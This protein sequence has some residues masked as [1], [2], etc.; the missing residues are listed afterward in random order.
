MAV[1]ATDLI[2]IVLCTYNRSQSLRQTLECLATQQ[3]D[4]FDYEVVVVD[5]NSPDDTKAVVE[6]CQPLFG[7]RLRYVFEGRQ[8]KPYALNT[9][10]AAARGRVLALTDDDVCPDPRWLCRLAE[11]FRTSNAECVFGKILP[12]WMGARPAWL[13]AFFLPQLA[14]LDYGDQAFLVTS[15]R[16]LFFGANVALTKKALARVG[17]FNVRL[18]NQGGR[19]GGE[20]DTDLF[21]RL[22]AA[23]ARI[24]YAPEAVVYHK[25]PA[26]RLRLGYFRKWHFDHGLVSAYVTPCTRGRGVLGV[27]FWAIRKFLTHLQGYLIGLCTGDRERRLANEMRLICDLGLFVEKGKI[28]A[29]RRLACGRS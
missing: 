28:A 22:L 17:P 19:M 21:E 3:A 14:L 13:S 25:V 18:G 10:V 8:G 7:G 9:G 11:V 6:R 12:L 15:D 4:G 5:N 24:A 1:S 16:H 26:E 2:S 23:G 27:P 20:E 29:G